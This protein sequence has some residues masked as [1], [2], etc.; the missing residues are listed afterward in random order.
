MASKS[1][2]EIM[3]KSRFLEEQMVKILREADEVPAAELSKNHGVSDQTIYTWRKRFGAMN[4]VEIW[5]PHELP[6]AES[7]A[8]DRVKLRRLHSCR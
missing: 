2:G 7:V 5:H 1:T 4:A 8:A 3:H 6:A